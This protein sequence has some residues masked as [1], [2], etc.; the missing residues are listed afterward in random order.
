MSAKYENYQTEIMAVMVM[1]A[2]NKKI[3]ST[4]VVIAAFY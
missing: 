3:M 2:G 1:A 4:E